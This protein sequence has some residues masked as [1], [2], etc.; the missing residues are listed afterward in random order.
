MF[1]IPAASTR[2]LA[3]TLASLPAGPPPLSKARQSVRQQY[4]LPN[5]MQKRWWYPGK[6]A[7]RLARTG[8]GHLP[9]RPGWRGRANSITPCGGLG[10]VPGG[11]LHFNFT[12]WGAN[13]SPPP[14]QTFELKRSPK[15]AVGT[16]STTRAPWTRGKRYQPSPPQTDPWLLRW[17]GVAALSI[18]G[19]A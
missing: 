7:A 4:A 9:V 3:T 13:P 18:I 5:S 8:G 6:L 14:R 17:A 10:G 1:R 12:G 2:S 19:P 16:G 15:Y 11:S